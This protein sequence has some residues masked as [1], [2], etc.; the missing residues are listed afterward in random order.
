M[1]NLKG[2]GLLCFL[3]I[4]IT[5]TNA[6]VKVVDYSGTLVVLTKPAE[7]II[8][9]SPHITENMFSAGAGDKIVASVDYANF[10]DAAKALPRVGGFNISSVETLVSYKPDLIIFWGSGNPQKL[11]RRLRKLNYPVYVDEPKKLEDVARSIKDFGTLTGTQTHANKIADDYL[12]QLNTLSLTYREARKVGILYQIWHDPLQ[13]LGSHHLVSDV[14]QIC[15]GTNVYSDAVSIAP[16][17]SLE[18][19]FERNPEV[20]LASGVDD[21]PPTW[22][23]E[24]RKYP[25]LSAVKHDNLLFIPPDLIQRHTLRILQGTE[26]LC[27]QLDKVRKKAL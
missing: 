15:G 17:I 27:A 18:S 1:K 4:C 26:N 13:T 14:M 7:R 3:F 24:W 21:T 2:I 6:E 22:L 20:I 23:D 12:K 16:V 19:V 5:P 8:T 9:L 25:Q 10:P 11:L